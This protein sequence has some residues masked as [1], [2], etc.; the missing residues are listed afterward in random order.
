MSARRFDLLVVNCGG[1]VNSFGMLA[2][3]LERGMVDQ[4]D[5]I[6]FA[7][8]GGEKPE[9]YRMLDE[10][11]SWLALNGFCPMVRVQNSGMYQ[12]LENN[13]LTKKM[14][15]SI[16]Y[17]YKSCSDKYK[18]RPQDQLVKAW[19]LAQQAWADGKVVTRAIGYDAGEPQRA[20]IYDGNGYQF[21]YPLIEW[22]W[23]RLECVQAIRRVGL[24]VPGKSACFYCPS[25]K[26]HEVLELKR[27]HPDLFAR[28]VAMEENAAETL[29]S[30]RGLGRNWSWSE[31]VAADESQ[32]KMFSEA[33]DVPCICSDGEV[34]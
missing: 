12:T 18:I 25:S 23:S 4:V 17:G 8:T 20:K 19:P 1:G 3:I 33:P 30:I 14:L 13:C 11:D 26:K 5:L 24:T 16:V 7:D 21:W 28:A 6:S 32:F 15:P 31:L 9:T 2:G 29:I 34:A 27:S 10:L 22:G